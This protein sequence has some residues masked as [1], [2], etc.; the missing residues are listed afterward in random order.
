M[1]GLRT[2]SI[3][4]GAA[5]ALVISGAGGLIQFATDSRSWR[6]VLFLVILFGFLFGG[7]VAGRGNAGTAARHGAVASALAFLVFQ[8]VAATRRVVVGDDVSVVGIVFNAF[9]AAVCGTLGGMIA[10]RS[11]G[12]EAVRRSRRQVPGR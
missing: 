11:P 2:A 7:F 3:L 5:Y 10:T 4:E 1:R 12:P 6:G 9:T 8:G